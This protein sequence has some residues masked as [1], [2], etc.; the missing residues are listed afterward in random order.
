MKEILKRFLALICKMIAINGVF[1]IIATIAFFMDKIEGTQWIIC[2]GA[3]LSYRA[4]Q[5]IKDLITTLRGK[6]ENL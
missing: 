4:I 6:N 2:S 1:F 3:V 5:K